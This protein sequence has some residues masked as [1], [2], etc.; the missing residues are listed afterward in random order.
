MGLTAGLLAP[1]VLRFYW[2]RLNGTGFAVGTLVGGLAAVGQ[3]LIFP[4][5]NALLKDVVAWSGCSIG[6]QFAEAIAWLPDMHE[7][8]LFLF[9]LSAGTLGTIVGTY[10]DGPT[11]RRVL[12]RFYHTTRPFGL[13]RPLSSKLGEADRKQTVAEHRRDITALPFA[14]TWQVALYMVPMLVLIRDVSATVAWATVCVGSFLGLYLVWLRHQPETNEF[15]D[16][17]LTA[18]PEE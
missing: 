6:E 5:T 16:G 8:V 7:I 1:S 12:A 2:W 4:D 13:W 17:S 18:F 14:L 10:F 9:V 11:D 15:E 3:R